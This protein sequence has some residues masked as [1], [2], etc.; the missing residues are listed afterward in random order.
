MLHWTFVTKMINERLLLSCTSSAIS[1]CAI[2]IA[3][4]TSGMSQWFTN[5]PWQCHTSTCSALV[6]YLYWD[7]LAVCYHFRAKSNSWLFFFLLPTF[8][9]LSL[10]LSPASTISHWNVPFNMHIAIVGPLFFALSSSSSQPTFIRPPRK[11]WNAICWMAWMVAVHIF[12]NNE[13]KAQASQQLNFSTLKDSLIDFVC[14]SSW[15]NAK[16]GL[17]Q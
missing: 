6:L 10:I 17:K 2:F 16:S 1:M 3:S 8:Q 14:L 7:H 11:K 9:H 5:L 15:A 4:I 13:V 12:N